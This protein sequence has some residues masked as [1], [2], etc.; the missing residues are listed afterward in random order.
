RGAELAASNP[1]AF[2]KVV[3]SGKPT[4]R[5][6]LLYSSG[7]TGR[8]KGTHVSHSFLLDNASR[9]LGVAELR[10]GAEYLSYISPAWGTEHVFGV[11]IGLI[12]P[13]VVNFPERPESVL[14]DLREIGVECLCF[15]PRQWESLASD[16]QAKLLD[17]APLVRAFCDWA[18]GVG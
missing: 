1:A 5:A 11:S 2:E 8:P 13:M 3:A 4:D 9:I 7:T 6:V 17:A 10:P 12:N 15:T 16:Q 14:H 18:L